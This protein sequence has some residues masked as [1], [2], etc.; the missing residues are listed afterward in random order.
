LKAKMALVSKEGPELFIGLVGAIGTDLQQVIDPLR[1]NLQRVGYIPKVLRLSQ[2]LTEFSKYKAL[3][4]C[5]GGPE[6]VRIDRYM[7]AGDNLRETLET[8]DAFALLAISRIRELRSE[9]TGKEIKPASR[10]AY[11]LN[12][13][14][15]PDEIETLRQI[16]GE[17]FFVLSVY[18]PRHERLSNLAKRIAQSRKEY[19]P[20]KFEARANELIERD[21][22]E[23]DKKLGQNVR[24][25]FPLAD[26]FVTAQAEKDINTQVQRFIDLLF[27]NPFVTPTMDEYAMFHAKAAALRSADLSR[28]VGAVVTTELGE[29]IA[30]GCNEV[31][32]AG[33]GAVWEGRDLD[34]KKDYRDF[35]IGFDASARMRHANV[36]EVL[37]ALQKKKWLAPRLEKLSTEQLTDRAL[38]EGDSPPLGGTRIASI[39]E[40][41]RIVHAEMF[42]ISDAARRGISTLGAFLYSTTFPCHMCARHIVSSGIKRVVYVEPYPKS[43]AKD[44]YRRSIRVD[45]DMEADSDAVDF[46]PFV[47]ISPRRFITFFEM[48]RRK[49]TKGLKT[50]WKPLEATPRCR[51]LATY[52]DVEAMHLAVLKPKAIEFGLVARQTKPS[53]R[54]RE[55]R[56]GKGRMVKK[57]TR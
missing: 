43:L 21:E 47:G 12:S 4:R 27:A 14:K 48:P 23:A 37:D 38:Y 39:L 49:D 50:V 7:D 36:G 24:D 16:Y 55:R 40:F 3:I 2:L 30:A 11:I 32:Q 56:H 33:G 53:S 22:I 10:Q 57:A 44:L 29:L 34:R 54:V 19:D 6:D 17:A 18:S 35:A 5:D 1:N 26:V 20:E 15:H 31:P 45:G 42:A 8:G 9:N 28:Q 46:E 41:G 25:T 51:S 52:T 13:L